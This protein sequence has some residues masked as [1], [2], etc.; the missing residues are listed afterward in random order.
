MQIELTSYYCYTVINPKE[1]WC[2]SMMNYHAKSGYILPMTLERHF[3]E[4]Q[5]N[6]GVSMREL[7]SL[8]ELLKK[9]LE[10]KLIS[11]RSVFVNYSLHDVSHSRSIILAIERFLGEDR[12]R[13]LTPTD[14]FMLLICAY[15]HDYGMA[16]SYDKIY[17]I[18]GSKEFESYLR[19][20]EYDLSSLEKEDAQAIKNLLDHLNRNKT[21]IPIKDIYW[22]ITL[23]AQLYLRSDHWKGI[24]NLD[25]DFHGL[26]ENHLKGRFICGSEGIVEICMCHGKSFNDIFQ[27]TP[28]ADGIVG[29]NFHP[30]FVAAMLRLGDLLDLDNDRFPLWFVREVAQKQSLIPRLSYLHYY[31]HEAVSHL[32]ISPQKIEIR[33]DCE[34]EKGGFE[35]A[36]LISQWTGWLQQECFDLRLAWEDIAPENFG[37]PPSEPCINIFVAGKPYHST[38]KKMQMQMSQER[39]MR[40][41]E[42]TNIYQDKYVGIREVIQ[43]AID[44]SLIKLWV[45]I[46]HNVHLKHNLS[47][48]SAKSGLRLTDFLQGNRHTIFADYDILVEVIKDLEH[49]QILIIVKDKGIG[50]AL[51]D[52]EYIADIG[53]SKENNTR[54]RNLM[55]NM[56]D[57][58]KPSGIFGIGLQSVFQ[59]TDCIKFYTRQPNQPERLIV[60]HSYGK[61][62]GKIDVH[63]IPENE[64]GMFY[65]N[66]IQGT[67]VEIAIDPYK[68]LASKSSKEP[69]NN[70]LYYDT[71]FDVGKEI[72]IAY[73]EIC[74]VCKGL[75]KSVKCDYFNIFYQ[76]ITKDESGN[77][78]KGEK[79]NLRRSFFIPY[80]DYRDKHM[81]TYIDSVDSILPFLTSKGEPF[82]FSDN[83]AHYWDETTCRY[84]RLKIR[85]CE[86]RNKD[87]SQQVFLPET[88][89]SLYHVSYKFNEISNTETIYHPSNRTQNNHAG[90]LEWRILILDSDPMKYMNIDR[91]RLKEGAI[92]EQEL[93][94]IRG[95]ILQKWCEYFC[96]QDTK[97][98]KNN[99]FKEK[100]GI[101]LSLILLF[102]QNVST[103]QFQKFI[104]P[105]QAYLDSMNLVVGTEQ[106]PAVCFWNPKKLFQ[107]ELPIGNINLTDTNIPDADVQM[108]TPET[109]QHFPRRL[110][111]IASIHITTERRKIYRFRFGPIL[112][113]YTIQMSDTAK[114][115]DYA[116]AF[117]LHP[118]RKEHIDYATIQKKV[119]K[120]NQEFPHLAIPCY[121]HTFSQ[122]GNYTSHLDTCIRW[123][124]LSPFDMNAAK[125]IKQSF[126]QDCNMYQEFINVVKNSNQFEKCVNYIL[127][128]RYENTNQMQVKQ[129]ILDEYEAFIAQYYK[130]IYDNRQSMTEYLKTACNI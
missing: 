118:D 67:N 127:K 100:P 49:N 9:D 42:G 82:N 128:V 55:E 92:S 16:K 102:Y 98:P 86:L 20:L 11:S 34:T 33:A 4:L 87:I 115:L 94:N 70:F 57:W 43:N 114:L 58:I 130:A 65:D 129:L 1:R 13:M 56:P 66:T 106:I 125:I 68:M 44:A 50:I 31:K 71:Q 25:K 19:T 3:E 2:E 38:N 107:V 97:N 14:T 26:F 73:A 23:A 123:Y 83:I 81:L 120:P 91:D 117:D 112:S 88:T 37:M 12:I 105:Y 109:L 51:N 104:A 126:S 29:D 119:F 124:I 72:D 41:L 85:P 95:P 78:S 8:Y 101:L 69:G 15:A 99:R 52:I 60:L 30:R 35:T 79:R 93:L 89:Q 108:I 22:S 39:V 27:L 110:V 62:R 59:L 46:T 7:Y 116:C 45:D 5:A 113:P 75:I 10:D 77:D 84:Y 80:N 32:F 21:D 6:D 122:G 17:D 111:Q 54:L 90:F 36:D 103:E 48:N 121:P 28:M 18:L 53:S 47:K 40:L 63:D 96:E 64:D 74:Q 61:S 76:E 24:V